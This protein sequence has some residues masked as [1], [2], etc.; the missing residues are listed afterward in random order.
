LAILV[1]L[2]A[3][4]S[5][6]PPAPR[7]APA[8]AQQ[9]DELIAASRFEDA[10]ELAD[11]LAALERWR[12]RRRVLHHAGDLTGALAAGHRGLEAA[13]ADLEL[14]LG[15]A[16]VAVGLGDTDEVVEL[17]A[18]LRDGVERLPVTAEHRGWWVAKAQEYQHHAD[19]LRTLRQRQEAA[20]RRAR[21]VAAIALGA[22]AV[23]I[24][25]LG[26]GSAARPQKVP[27]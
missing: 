19:G 2:P 26:R 17:C 27:P 9:V 6:S 20:G 8:V 1:L 4:A 7:R 3:L 18:R 21:A 5:A 23:A 11:G 22:A 24:V 12:L 15:T 13:P 14:L 25:V 16:D 10:L